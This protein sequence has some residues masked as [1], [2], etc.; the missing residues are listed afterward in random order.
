M[1]FQKPYKYFHFLKNI[2]L[3]VAMYELKIFVQGMPLYITH[4]FIA[5]K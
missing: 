4:S 1:I 5:M 2:F 3:V